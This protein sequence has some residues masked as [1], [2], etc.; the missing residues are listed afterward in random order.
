MREH[1]LSHYVCLMGIALLTLPHRRQSGRR[2]IARLGILDPNSHVVQRSPLANYSL[3]NGHILLVRMEK[4]TLYNAL[5]TWEK[6]KKSL[7]SKALGK[8]GIPHSLTSLESCNRRTSRF[9]AR[10]L[11]RG[12]NYLLFSPLSFSLSK[13]FSLF[14]QIV[15]SIL[16][17]PQ[18][19]GLVLVLPK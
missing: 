2:W 12:G 6:R 4:K 14:F 17:F 9:S 15:I 8:S 16:S 3:W 11:P 7:L 1:F 10:L 13:D 19:L 5:N 18:T